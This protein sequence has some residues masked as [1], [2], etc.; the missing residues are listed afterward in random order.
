MFPTIGDAIGIGNV[1]LELDGVNTSG[2]FSNP[3]G[4]VFNTSLTS[5]EGSHNWRIFAN[6]TAGNL[7]FT[8]LRLYSINII[9]FDKTSLIPLNNLLTL[10]GMA[11]VL[12]S[13]LGLVFG[14]T[15]LLGGKVS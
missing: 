12:F 15:G 11:F 2:L 4:D 9:P 7:G 1:I 8:E 13:I 14:R 5:S 10:A 6:D 3:F